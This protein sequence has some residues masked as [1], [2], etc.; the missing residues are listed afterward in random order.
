MVCRTLR[1]EDSGVE[2]E[3][4]D[5]ERCVWGLRRIFPD[6]SAPSGAAQLQRG[7]MVRGSLMGKRWG[8]S[9]KPQEKKGKLSHSHSFFCHLRTWVA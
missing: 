6:G 5:K 8:E 2:M 9:D 7:G 1:A 3:T 4:V